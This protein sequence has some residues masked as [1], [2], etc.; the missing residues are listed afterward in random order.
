LTKLADKYSSAI[1]AIRHLTKGGSLK[2]IYRGLGSIDFTA[3]ARSVLL[4]GC[5]PDELAVRGI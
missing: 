2:P 4:A 1:I 5:D 3:S